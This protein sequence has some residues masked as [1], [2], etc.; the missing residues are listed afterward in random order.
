MRTL[1]SYRVDV[2]CLSE[3]R[4]PGSGHKTVKVPH[5]D[6]V[7][8]L[9]YSGVNDN[10]GRHGVVIALSATANAALLDFAPISPRLARIR[11]KGSIANDVG[12]S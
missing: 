1:S 9:Y 3:V 12:R 11:L 2:A 6:A 7:Y 5:S 8:H 4:L 10:T